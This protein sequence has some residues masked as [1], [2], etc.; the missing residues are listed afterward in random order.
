VKASPQRR[1]G[2]RWTAVEEV[3]SL[4]HPPENAGEPRWRR[5]AGIGG[6]GETLA[7]VRWREREL[8]R[9]GAVRR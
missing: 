8:G 2:Q 6:R 3:W 5:L 7:K 4:A 9:G 1:N